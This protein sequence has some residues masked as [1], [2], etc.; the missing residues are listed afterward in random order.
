MAIEVMVQDARST[1]EGEAPPSPGRFSQWANLAASDGVVNAQLTVRIVDTEEICEI[2]SRY[3]GRNKSTNILSFCYN[4][5]PLLS[6]IGMANILG[7]L[8]ICSDVV[9]REAMQKQCPVENHWAHLTIHGVLHLLGYDH[10]TRRQAAEMESL[11]VRLLET[12]NI[13]NPYE[14][15]N[16][17][18]WTKRKIG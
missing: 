12:L 11:E 6:R 2:N 13:R 8:V 3:R 10:E 1:A 15:V 4:D 17:Q 5:E 18:I 16:D 9:Q 14:A 7:D